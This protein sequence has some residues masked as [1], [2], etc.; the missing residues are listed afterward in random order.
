VGNL[1]D[2]GLIVGES[3]DNKTLANL[4]QCGTQGGMRRSLRTNSLILISD[5]VDPFY[6]DRWNNSLFYYTGMG[7]TGDQDINFMQNKTLA[8]SMSNGVTVY[9][10]EKHRDK[11]Y[12]FAGQVQLAGD[13]FQ[14][15]QLDNEKQKRKVWIFPLRLVNSEG[16]LP[17]P[18][19]I[20]IE[21]QQR[22][23]RRAQRLS[24]A[25]LEI[26]A[27]NARSHV[28]VRTVS[29]SSFERDP[30]I[31][32]YT[33]RCANGV[34]QLCEQEAPFLGKD[35]RPY[36]ETHHIIWLSRGGEDTL[37]NTVAL[38]PNCH[39]KMHVLD[40]SCDIEKLL[41]SKAT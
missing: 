8:Q 13:P 14:E 18:E 20:V 15:E 40:L 29:M 1:F 16:A 25:E 36:L 34:C 33:K 41:K 3:I 9:L 32:E 21:R 6:H 22:E 23:A 27:K 10:F 35:N 31:S 28:G 5:H 37:Q 17:L 4:F 19:T 26:R 11:E 2:P 12:T 30:Y 39:R 7:L 24:Q 38:C